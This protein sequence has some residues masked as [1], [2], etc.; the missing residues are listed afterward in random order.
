MCCFTHHCPAHTYYL[1][2]LQIKIQLKPIR[3]AYDML[4]LFSC[5]TVYLTTKRPL[6]FKSNSCSQLFHCHAAEVLCQNEKYVQQAEQ[7]KI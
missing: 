3:P 1:N 6:A 5:F 4:S 2:D 7:F